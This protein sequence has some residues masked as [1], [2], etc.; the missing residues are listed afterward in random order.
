MISKFS[1]KKPYTVFVVVIALIVVGIVALTRMTADLL[2]NMTLPYV[3]VITT[4]MGASP[5]TI[6][7]EITSPIESALATTSNLKN[8][9]SVSYNSYSTVILEYEQTSN[10]DAT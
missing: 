3:I 5:E 7:K 8:I 9:Q 4:D 10:M 6:E 1:V 2:P